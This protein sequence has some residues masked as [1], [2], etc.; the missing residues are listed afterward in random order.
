MKTVGCVFVGERTAQIISIEAKLVALN[1]EVEDI[2][3]ELNLNQQGVEDYKEAF[4]EL[5][6][7]VRLLRDK[8]ITKSIEG[9]INESLIT[10]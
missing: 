1:V 9:A 10:I 3:K 4:G 5:L 8:S 7:S 2:M 6:D